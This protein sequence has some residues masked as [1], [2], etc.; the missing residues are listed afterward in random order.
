MSYFWLHVSRT[1][2]CCA[3]KCI[4]MTI[5]RHEVK[6]PRTPH[7]STGRSAVELLYVLSPHPQGNGLAQLAITCAEPGVVYE[8]RR[9]DTPVGG[10]C[11]F[12]DSVSASKEQ[13]WREWEAS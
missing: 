13:R 10:G 3:C 12:V 11:A 5:P 2:A 8:P 6:D 4:R 7:G 1:V 9:W